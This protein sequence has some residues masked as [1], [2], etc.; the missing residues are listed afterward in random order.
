MEN[1][2]LV[3]R[4]CLIVAMAVTIIVAGIVFSY[5]EDKYATE[6]ALKQMEIEGSQDYA[7]YHEAMMVSESIA[8][9]AAVALIV[10]SACMIFGTATKKF[11]KKSRR[12]KK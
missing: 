9:T 1:K 3:L 10:I 4:I 6:L 11:I 12:K 7:I 8:Y 2:R 5:S